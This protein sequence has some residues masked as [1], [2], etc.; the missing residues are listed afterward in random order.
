MG[1]GLESKREKEGLKEEGGAG[2]G[3]ECSTRERRERLKNGGVGRRGQGEG[4]L[5][6]NEFSRSH[7]WRVA[8]R[9][10]E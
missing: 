7:S 1:K 2:N 8:L 9:K 4:N 5:K 3:E 10:P 6:T